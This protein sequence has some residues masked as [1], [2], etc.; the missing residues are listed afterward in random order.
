M[1]VVQTKLPGFAA[2]VDDEEKHVLLGFGTTDCLVCLVAMP[3]L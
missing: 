2:G 3:L 1:S